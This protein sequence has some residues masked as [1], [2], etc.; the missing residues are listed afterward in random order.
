MSSDRTKYKS[1]EGLLKSV[2]DKSYFKS[3]LEWH[4]DK[5][6][7][8]YYSRNIY[9]VSV[10]VMVVSLLVLYTEIRDW[11]PLSVQK[12][13]VLVNDNSTEKKL[14]LFQM[15][16]KYANP[17]FAVLEYLLKN[18]IRLNEQFYKGSLDILSL[19][20]RIQKIANNSSKSFSKNFQKTFEYNDARN[21]LY[22]VGKNGSR[23]LTV[24]DI[25]LLGVDESFLNQIKNFGDVF[26][27]MPDQ[28][29]AIIKIEEKSLVKDPVI[30]RYKVHIDFVFSGVIFDQENKKLTIPQFVVKNYYKTKL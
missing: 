5:Y 23:L 15:S 12:A 27:F 26:Y 9:F 20:Q 24:S 13:V 11:Y 30:E 16:D 14:Q 29:E 7:Y 28:A 17:D 3:G 10:V 25:T 21:L 1:E 2:E 6:L 4:L 19:D 8:P 22:R 18:F